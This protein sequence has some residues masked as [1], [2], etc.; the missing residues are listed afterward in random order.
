MALRESETLMRDWYAPIEGE[1]R[2]FLREN[3]TR[4]NTLHVDE[5]RLD[6]IN[7]LEEA[8]EAGENQFYELPARWSINGSPVIFYPS[9]D[10]SF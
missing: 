6:I 10:L 5:F 4:V 9:I 3:L 2:E 1:M 7:A 8:I